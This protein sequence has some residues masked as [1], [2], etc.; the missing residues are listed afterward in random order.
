MRFVWADSGADMRFLWIFE[1]NQHQVADQTLSLSSLI[2]SAEILAIWAEIKSHSLT[3]VS[4]QVSM[5]SEARWNRSKV[6]WCDA[7]IQTE[8]REWCLSLACLECTHG[9]W[10]RVLSAKCSETSKNQNVE[11]ASNDTRR[12][13][14]LALRLSDLLFLRMPL[15]AWG[16]LEESRSCWP[17]ICQRCLPLYKS[18]KNDLQWRLSL[19]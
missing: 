4:P 5:L 15:G 18:V 13:T 16:Q 1:W 9:Q 14:G 10:A 12:A 7:W 8:P 3:L 19:V 6:P 2:N 11:T 17:A